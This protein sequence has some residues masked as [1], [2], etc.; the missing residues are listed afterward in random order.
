[1]KNL[2]P[3]ADIFI[4]DGKAEDE[5]LAA[6]THL[7]VGAHADDLELLAGPAILDGFQKGERSF[8]GVTCSD[9]AD[10]PRSGAHASR[11]AEEMK[12]IRRQEQQQAAKA[13]AYGVL[14]QLDY[15]SRDIQ[16]SK[17][18]AL[19]QDLLSIT[20]ACRPRTVYSHN[21]ADKHDTHVAVIAAL[22]RAI[23]WM[24]PDER[25][26]KLYGCEVWRGL[27]W[28]DDKEKTRFDLNGADP[29]LPSLLREFRS[30][31]D[32]GKRYDAAFLGRLR[33]NATFHDPHAVDQAKFV[34]LAMDLTPLIQN[35]TMDLADFVAAR[36][37]RF[38]SD[39]LARIRK[40][41]P[42]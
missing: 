2:N 35:N 33:A 39:V 7:G 5:A 31:I 24:N 30:Q 18:P 41:Q 14:V 37:E 27:D 9:G 34:L 11:S 3:K 17:N 12:A 28:L 26:Q 16:D 29:L 36:I 13:G 40:F 15:P 19:E 4:P 6:I 1:M 32:G 10:S 23:R 25:P 21:P 8:A 42:F 20:E 22:I 38:Q